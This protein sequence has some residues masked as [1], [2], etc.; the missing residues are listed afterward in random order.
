MDDDDQKTRRNLVTY[1]SALLLLTW[2]G[3][4]FSALLGKLIEIKSS[5]PEDWRLWVAG[6]VVLVYLGIRYSFS[7]EG[8]RYQNELRRDR[9]VIEVDTAIALAQQQANYFTRTGREPAV[10]SGK[11]T[12][13]IEEQS[14]GMGDVPKRGG[15]PKIELSMN[16]YGKAP[17]KFTMASELVWHLNGKHLGSS[18]GGASIE[19]NV[20]GVYRLYV[21]TVSRLHAF[22]YSSSSINYLAPVFL[23]LAAAVVLTGKVFLA[24]QSV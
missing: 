2:L 21:L 19:V 23:S 18:S 14:A 24:Y 7:T 9:E 13:H 1:S 22:L 11:L 5:Q 16:E 20:A 8:Q 6:L 3:I 4:P 17:Y 10:F 15:R 12:S